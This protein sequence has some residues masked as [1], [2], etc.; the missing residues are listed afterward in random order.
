MTKPN[1]M[2]EFTF[3]TEWVEKRGFFLVLA[4][5]LGG[6]NACRR[7]RSWSPPGMFPT[8]AARRYTVWRP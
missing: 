5:F 6:L 4:F 8:P 1:S 2:A 3:Q 7:P